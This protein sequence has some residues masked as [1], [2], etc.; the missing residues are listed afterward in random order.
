[1]RNPEVPNHEILGAG[2]K[3]YMKEVSF[4]SRPKAKVD[5]L[6]HPDASRTQP[7]KLFL[8]HLIIIKGHYHDDFGAFS[9]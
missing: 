6:W 8:N 5:R 4:S 1:M 9:V 2:T 3:A 7:Y